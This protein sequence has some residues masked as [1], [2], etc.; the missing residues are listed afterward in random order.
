[1]KQTELMPWWVIPLGILNL[2]HFGAVVLAGFLIVL[3]FCAYFLGLK[4]TAAVLFVLPTAIGASQFVS[5][6][7][8]IRRISRLRERGGCLEVFDQD[9]QRW[10]PQ[11]M[12]QGVARKDFPYPDPWRPITIGYPGLHIELRGKRRAVEHLFPPG[13]EEHRD[14]VF[15]LLVKRFGEGFER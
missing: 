11:T 7:R 2:V 12:I 3:G 1:M 10:L 4:T 13:L 15:R 14:A 8:H 6:F 5:R 9:T